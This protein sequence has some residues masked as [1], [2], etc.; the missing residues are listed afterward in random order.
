M[1]AM[2]QLVLYMI[3]SVDGFISDGRGVVNPRA[4]WDEEI[5]RF[6]LETYQHADAVVFGRG[7]HDAYVGHWRKVADGTIAPQTDL[8][9]R[10]ARRLMAMPKYVVSSSLTEA[11]NNTQILSGD[12]GARIAELKRGGSGNLLLICGASLFARLTT[13]RLIDEYMLFMCPHAMGNGDHLFRAL[14]AAVDLLRAVRA[15]RIGREP[16]LLRPVHLA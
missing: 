16:A 13:A 6:Y 7:I 5:Q 1:T 15:V 3:V 8:E 4:Q 12:I 9:L 2:R 14:P 10:W 11:K